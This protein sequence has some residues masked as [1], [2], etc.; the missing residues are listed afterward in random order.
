LK[1]KLIA[2]NLLL[3]A[4][5]GTVAWQARVRSRETQAISRSNLNAVVKPVAPPPLSPTPRPEAPPATKYA[6]VATNDLFSKDRNPTVVIEPPKIAAPKPMPPLPTVYGVLALPSGIKAIMA[7]KPGSGS[8]PVHTGDTV[9]EFKIV[10]LDSQ[11]VTFEWD[12]KEIAKPIE[13]LID[14][15]GRTAPDA[16]SP[17]AAS[18]PP[19]GQQ[20][21]PPPPQA[22]SSPVLGVD[23]GTAQRPMRACRPDDTSPAGT[24]VDGYRKEVTP[25]PFGINCHWVQGQ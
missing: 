11:N 21:L 25:T 14:R 23:I 16:N 3:L 22:P 9:G 10:A 24:F 17:A 5:V 6:E 1:V 4:G 7:D 15:T 19:Q 13:D 20:P 12:G 2:L 18:A 8:K